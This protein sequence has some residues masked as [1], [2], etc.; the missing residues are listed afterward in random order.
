M[1]IRFFRLYFLRAFTV[2][3]RAMR[4]DKAAQSISIISAAPLPPSERSMVRKPGAARSSRS[5]TSS[6]NSSTHAGSPNVVFITIGLPI[7][8]RSSAM[9]SSSSEVLAASLLRLR[10]M[11]SSSSGI[12]RASA[13]SLVTLQA[14]RIPPSPGFD[15]R[16]HIQTTPA[17]ITDHLHEYLPYGVVGRNI[18]FQ[19]DPP[20][21]GGKIR[22]HRVE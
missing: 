2:A 18:G 21:S 12:L 5:V 6:Q 1:R 8:F 14:G 22:Q 16:P 19:P 15:P 7:I 3:G 11:E 4:I 13:I 10:K 17:A 9:K 20:F